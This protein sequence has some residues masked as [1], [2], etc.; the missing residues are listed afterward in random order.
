MKHFFRNYYNSFD[1]LK[2]S[3][4]TMNLLCR[5]EDDDAL[6]DFYSWRYPGPP[7][8]LATWQFDL[9]QE[10][11]V[12][13]HP[14]ITRAHRGDLIRVMIFVEDRHGLEVRDCQMTLL[15]K[16]PFPTEEPLSTEQP[17]KIKRRLVR[18]WGRLSSI[19]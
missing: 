16:N 14:L 4:E 8:D 5:H 2:A 7:D 17:G 11:S 18:F 10:V 12:E 9:K 15:H 6:D 3:F 13:Q 1:Q 19:I